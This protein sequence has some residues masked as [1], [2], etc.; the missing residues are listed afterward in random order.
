M[1]CGLTPELTGCN[2]ICQIDLAATRLLP[3]IIA[4]IPD[5]MLYPLLPS[6]RQA[7]DKQ[8]SEADPGPRE[9]AHAVVVE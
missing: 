5:C 3:E 1:Y 9:T 6:C 8:V 2:G 7:D 4:E